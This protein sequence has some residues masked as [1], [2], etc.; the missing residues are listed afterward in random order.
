[1]VFRVTAPQE[2]AGFLA[3]TTEERDFCRYSPAQENRALNR[4]AGQNELVET[5][6]TICAQLAEGFMV[7]PISVPDSVRELPATPER[8]SKPTNQAEAAGPG[9][10]LTKAKVEG[11]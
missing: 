4:R 9:V 2:A 1:M 10:P 6:K 3:R 5:E 11:P 8:L 7:R